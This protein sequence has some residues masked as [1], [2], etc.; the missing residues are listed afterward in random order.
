MPCDGEATSQCLVSRI[1][2]QVVFE[3]GALLPLLRVFDVFSIQMQYALPI[4]P[5][6][7]GLY[8]LAWKFLVGF[9]NQEIGIA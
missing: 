5:I 2:G 4:I 1:T 9:L 8:Y 7:I 3:L 6:G